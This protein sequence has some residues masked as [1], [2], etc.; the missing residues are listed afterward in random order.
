VDDRFSAR[1]GGDEAAR[2]YR[3]KYE[4]SFLRRLSARREAALV[5]RLLDRAGGRGGEVLDAPCGAGRLVPTLL[6]RAERVVGVDLSPAMV[7]AATEALAGEV[8]SGRVAL[9]VGSAEALPFQRG[10][11]RAAVCWRLLHHLAAP[12]E[13]RRVLAELA[14][15]ARDAV[16]VSFADAGTLRARAARR[17]GRP[18]RRAPIAVETLAQDARAAGL[19]LAAHERLS[20][21]FSALAGALLVPTRA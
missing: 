17:R 2:A 8:A 12:E 10:A 5:G 3:A 15:V 9:S 13:R 4:R 14:R 18:S 19:D 11:F 1:Y 21:A 6:S 20:S 16:V 7:A